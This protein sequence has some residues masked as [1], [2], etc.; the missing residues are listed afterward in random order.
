MT[1][2][3]ARDRRV[4]RRDGAR[5]APRRWRAAW[6]R[7]RCRRRRAAQQ[8]PTISPS[9][10]RVVPP[11]SVS[12]SASSR[13]LIRPSFGVRRS[14]RE[15]LEPVA[16]QLASSL[17]WRAPGSSAS[18]HRAR[19][20]RRS[21]AAARRRSA[22]GTPS[23]VKMTSIGSSAESSLT[24]SPPPLRGQRIEQ[25]RRRGADEGFQR[26]DAPR[27]ERAAHQLAQPIVAR[28]IH[29]DHHRRDSNSC[30]SMRSISRSLGRAVGLPVVRRRDA[31]RGSATAPRSRASGCGSSGACSRSQR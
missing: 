24:K 26:G 25:P 12:T 17:R 3:S 13:P 19:A 1:L 22:A 15:Q 18:R 27:R 30:G 5:T 6:S 29:E 7:S 4:L 23:M 21:S 14:S 9:V 11:S 8:K 31:R 10:R 16:H 20:T 2:G 28:R